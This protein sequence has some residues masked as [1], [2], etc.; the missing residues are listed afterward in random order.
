MKH[1]PQARARSFEED[2][3]RSV[4]DQMR[5]RI[6]LRWHAI[7]GILD[8]RAAWSALAEQAAVGRVR[9]Y[10]G[11]GKFQPVDLTRTSL[12]D[13]LEDYPLFVGPTNATLARLNEIG[14]AA[15]GAPSEWV[16]GTVRPLVRG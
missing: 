2:L 15:A 14:R 6:F 7:T 4:L 10:R 1:R 11:M 9:A 5:F 8:T 16:S 3:L 13:V 12:D